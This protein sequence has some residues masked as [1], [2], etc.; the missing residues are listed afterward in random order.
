MH[1]TLVC[2]CNAP[3]PLSAQITY[4]TTGSTATFL[5]NLPVASI[6]QSMLTISVAADDVKLIS[7]KAPAA[8]ASVQVR[9][10]ERD[11]VWSLARA[12]ERL[13]TDQK[14]KILHPCRSCA[15]KTESHAGPSRP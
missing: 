5:L 1:L 6:T 8:I 3:P 10:C 4:S 9:W 12:C 7:N 11:W 15:L 14:T 2:L 13:A